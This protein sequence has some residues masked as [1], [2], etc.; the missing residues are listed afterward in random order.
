MSETTIEVTDAALAKTA[1]KRC[2]TA[3]KRASSAGQVFWSAPTPPELSKLPN[4]VSLTCY[5]KVTNDAA[6]SLLAQA[7]A[8][9]HLQRLA[10]IHA[11]LSVIPDEIAA[12]T[13]L[14]RL[15]FEQD[16]ITRVPEAIGGAS[17]LVL[18]DLS[19]N[20]L[21][22]VDPAITSLRDLRTLR[23]GGSAYAVAPLT[24]LPVS[25]S[26]T[27]LSLQWAPA[28]RTSL[29]SWPALRALALHGDVGPSGMPPELEA[30]TELRS[31]ALAYDRRSSLPETVRRLRSLRAL[32]LPYSA[33]TS[34]PAWLTELTEL[35][36]LAL[37]GA[38]QL[39]PLHIVDTA[40]RLP[41]LARIELPYPFPADARGRLR[42]AGFVSRTSN[43][44]V[45]DRPVGTEAP[46]ID[47]FPEI[48]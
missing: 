8:H 15:R 24:T 10:V 42:K 40:L 25:S 7:A 16:A 47:P 38:K 34:L 43:P 27:T 48:R 36:A 30:L 46:E 20:P 41:R 4:V 33:F 31:L 28:L 37:H 9:P 32:W 26:V 19:N 29:T 2:E 3:P 22:H 14:Y 5:G 45:L 13:R 44:S 35:R 23:V 18:L 12:L 6:V 17:R 11:P 1:Y 39:D 21:A